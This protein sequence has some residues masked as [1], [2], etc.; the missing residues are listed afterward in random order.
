MG[1]LN[2]YNHC[3]LIIKVRPALTSISVWS[4]LEKHE[5]KSRFFDDWNSRSSGSMDTL[6]VHA[7]GLKASHENVKD[8]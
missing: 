7:S 1:H 4:L 8:I 3:N 5:R 2:L 6:A